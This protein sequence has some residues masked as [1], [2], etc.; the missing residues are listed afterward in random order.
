MFI[1]SNLGQLREENLTI[2]RWHNTFRDTSLVASELNCPSSSSSVSFR[3]VFFEIVGECSSI[4]PVEQTFWEV[5]F[6][7]L[8]I[9][10]HECL[11]LVSHRNRITSVEI[12]THTH[13]GSNKQESEAGK[14]RETTQNDDDDEKRW[15]SSSTLIAL[16][17]RMY[18]DFLWSEIQWSGIQSDVRWLTEWKSD[19]RGAF[20]CEVYLRSP[21]IAIDRVLRLKKKLFRNRS[22]SS[23]RFPL[24]SIGCDETT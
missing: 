18:R 24:I 12:E 21:E 5:L 7:C 20:P 15:L 9:A 23:E 1:A 3:S 8:S 16:R 13:I 22:L 2:H 4:H 10:A 14:R 17:K 19:H 6:Y 11:L